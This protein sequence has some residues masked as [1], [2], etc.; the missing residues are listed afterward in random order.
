MQKDSISYGVN[1]DSLC[2]SYSNTPLFSLKI[3]WI[4]KY[5]QEILLSVLGINLLIRIFATFMDKNDL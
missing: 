2:L 4:C 3:L 5:P 1:K